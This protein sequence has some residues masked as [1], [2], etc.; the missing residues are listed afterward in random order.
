MKPVNVLVVLCF[1]MI[2]VAGN[3]QIIRVPAPSAALSAVAGAAAPAIRPQLAPLAPGAA[4]SAVSLLPLASPAPAL[5]VAAPAPAPAAAVKPALVGLESGAA[6]FVQAERDGASAGASLAISASLFDAASAGSRADMYPVSPAPAAAAPAW[7]DNP[8]GRISI[9]G[10]QIRAIEA[11]QAME[12]VLEDADHVVLDKWK[13]TRHDDDLGRI[14]R[15]EILHTPAFRVNAGV[16]KNAATTGVRVN[17]KF[18]GDAVGKIGEAVRMLR[19]SGRKILDIR[20]TS[21]SEYGKILAADVVH[22]SKRDY[23]SIMSG[24]ARPS[25]LPA[26]GFS[27]N[28]PKAARPL[29]REV[30]SQE[31]NAALVKPLVKSA[32]REYNRKNGLEATWADLNL[33][34]HYFHEGEKEYLYQVVVEVGNRRIGVFVAH[35][36][37][38]THRLT[39]RSNED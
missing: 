10:T 19:A 33:Y 1:P 6:R 14:Q 34:A 39:L 32:L 9:S 16:V 28:V 8:V 30:L 11:T 18:G 4:L 38:S 21:T 20:V 36:D 17:G 23:D 13:A 3:A 25:L 26:L 37:K 22:I 29:L 31:K 5:L 15:T 35:I 27:G 24:A 2:S 12:R 7:M